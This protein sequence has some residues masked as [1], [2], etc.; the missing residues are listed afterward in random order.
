MTTRRSLLAAGGAALLARPQVLVLTQVFDSL[1]HHHRRAIVEH[2]NR[3]EDL[4]FINFSNRRDI[5][6]YSEYLYIEPD[7][8]HRFSVVSD[9]LA[10]ERTLDS[11]PGTPARSMP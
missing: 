8:H 7:R 4:T 2:I 11:E 6:S 10:F 3:A 1:A 9:L 5:A